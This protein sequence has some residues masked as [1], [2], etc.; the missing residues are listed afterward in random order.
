MG[1]YAVEF[2]ELVE[3]GEEDFEKQNFRPKVKK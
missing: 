1:I 3:K 2:K